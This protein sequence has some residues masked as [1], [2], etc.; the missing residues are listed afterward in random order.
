MCMLYMHVYVVCTHH[1][2]I[3]AALMYWQSLVTMALL[4]HIGLIWD[5][6]LIVPSPPCRT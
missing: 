5:H 1:W 3:A 6:A 2:A 4:C